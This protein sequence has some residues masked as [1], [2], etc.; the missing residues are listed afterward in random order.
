MRYQLINWMLAAIIAGLARLVMGFWLACYIPTVEFEHRAG[1]YTLMN[2]IY[3]L[4]FGLVWLSLR[5]AQG[6]Y[7]GK[8]TDPRGF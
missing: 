4:V 6:E 2:T 1:F 5:S 8:S 3:M 7:F